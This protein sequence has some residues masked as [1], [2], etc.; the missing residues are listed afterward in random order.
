MDD[1]TP[2]E[3]KLMEKMSPL[4]RALMPKLTRAERRSLA[5]HVTPENIEIIQSWIGTDEEIERI[6][7]WDRGSKYDDPEWQDFKPVDRSTADLYK[8]AKARYARLRTEAVESQRRS[9]LTLYSQ[10]NTGLL[11]TGLAGAVRCNERGEP[12]EGGGFFKGIEWRCVGSVEENINSITILPR[13][14]GEW[15]IHFG[16]RE[17]G[18]ARGIWIY[19]GDSHSLLQTAQLSGKVLP[20]HGFE[21]R[22]EDVKGNPVQLDPQAIRRAAAGDGE[23]ISYGREMKLYAFTRADEPGRALEHADTLSYRFYERF[24]LETECYNIGKKY[25]NFHIMREDNFD[26]FL[27]ETPVRE[28]GLVLLTA[29]LVCRRCRREMEEFRDLARDYPYIKA[30]VV[31]LSS[32][33]F[34]FYERVFGDMGGG[35]PDEFRKTAAGVTPFI[36]IYAPDEKGVLKFVEYISTGKAENTP[37]IKANMPVLDRYF[38]KGPLKGTEDQGADS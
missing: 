16:Q 17:D 36:I 38:S 15:E 28:K 22:V 26:E 35:D 8:R 3:R 12:D 23:K 9:D 27:P 4:H 34:K 19:T 31:N 1:L 5:Q 20:K 11:Y 30:V 21:T 13:E 25:G 2:H 33:Q 37:S 7:F 10:F 14:S 18:R 32:P 29:T 24:G 6:L